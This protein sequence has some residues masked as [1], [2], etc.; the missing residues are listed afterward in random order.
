MIWLQYVEIS[1]VPSQK[2]KNLSRTSLCGPPLPIN[3]LISAARL[4]PEL[5]SS[6]LEGQSSLPVH[7]K[8]CSA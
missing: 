8:T 3:S 4:S 7:I 6:I 5:S 1:M 2:F